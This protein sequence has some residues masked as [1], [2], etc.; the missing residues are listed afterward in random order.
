MVYG[1]LDHEYALSVDLAYESLKNDTESINPINIGDR[2]FFYFFGAHDV[3]LIEEN[4]D[5]RAM[6]IPNK[7]NKGYKENIA[8]YT[9][10]T[11]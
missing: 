4:P 3:D 10:P 2:I 11:L 8:E 9:D 7:I 6:Y 1:S 5:D